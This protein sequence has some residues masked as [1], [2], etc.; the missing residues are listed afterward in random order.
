MF[1]DGSRQLTCPEVNGASRRRP[2]PSLSPRTCAGWLSGDAALKRSAYLEGSPRDADVD[3]MDQGLI[4]PLDEPRHTDDS[5]TSAYPS[6]AYKR[7]SETGGTEG[8]R[9]VTSDALYACEVV[10]YPG[11]ARRRG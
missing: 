9:R 8:P 5:A 4:E 10:G 7:A 3:E 1:H 2:A 6:R 11:R